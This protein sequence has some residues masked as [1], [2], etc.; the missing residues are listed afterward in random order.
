MRKRPFGL[1]Q[2]T[3]FGSSPVLSIAL[4]VACGTVAGNPK[5]PGSAGSPTAPTAAT[6]DLS[7]PTIDFEVPPEATASEALLLAE[8]T[9]GVTDR[10]LLTAGTK[11]ATKLLKD[12]DALSRRVNAVL[13]S[14]RSAGGTTTSVSFKGKGDGRLGGRVFPLASADSG[15]EGGTFAYRAILCASDRPVV[16]F[17][18]SADG[19]KLSLTRDF[20]HLTDGGDSAVDMRSLVTVSRGTTTVVTMT[21]QGTWQDGEPSGGGPIL[22]ELAELATLTGGGYSYRMVG[23]RGTAAPSAGMASGDAYLVAKLQPRTNGSAG[24]DTEFVGYFKGDGR[25]SNVGFDEAA[26]DLWRPNFTGPRFC[27]G[28]PYKGKAFASR[29]ELYGTLADL[30]PIG[31]LSKSKPA[32]VALDAALSCSP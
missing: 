18:W 32:P 30:Q 21:N 7:L 4:V 11:R 27:M 16:D 13:R 26:A 15:A 10:T 3:A 9:V 17:R 29:A 31:V 12:I 14:E 19:K 5:K 22:T 8:E 6:F 25:C 24:Y 2:A 28:R 1:W 23:D 20:A